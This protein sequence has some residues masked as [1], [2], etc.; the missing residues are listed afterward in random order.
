MDGVQG[1]AL[2]VVLCCVDYGSCPRSLSMLAEKA[3]LAIIQW[4]ELRIIACE[5]E[6][7]SFVLGYSEDR[8]CQKI[9]RIW[10]RGRQDSIVCRVLGVLGQ[11][12]WGLVM[13]GDIV[14]A[15]S[16]FDVQDSIF[17][18]GMN[19][20]QEFVLVQEIEQDDWKGRNWEGEH[21]HYTSVSMQVGVVTSF[22]DR[23]VV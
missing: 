6:G 8:C 23:R 14:T 3:L 18:D 12:Q 17:F 4:E 1:S 13:D 11:S 22:L 9:Q 20:L 7:V 16:A 15:G 2:Y 5:V 21:L 19:V 10:K